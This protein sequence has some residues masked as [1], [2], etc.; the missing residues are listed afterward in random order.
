MKN[1]KKIALMLTPILSAGLLSACG[2]DEPMDRDVYQSQEE[3]LRDWNDGDLCSR[4]PDDDEREYHRSHG[5][6]YPVF[7]GP[8]YYRGSRTV[9]Y[10]GRTIAPTGKSSSIPSYTISSRSSVGARTSPSTPRSV[11]SGGFGGRSGSGGFG[12]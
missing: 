11:S 3:C 12:G 10:K 5:V 2:G 9:D 7:W 1:S 6:A 8:T 4:M